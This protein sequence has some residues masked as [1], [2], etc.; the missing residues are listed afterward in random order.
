MRRLKWHHAGGLALRVAG[1]ALAGGGP[2][3]IATLVVT[4]V[5]NL[6]CAHCAVANTDGAMH[7]Y[8]ELVREMRLLHAGGIR[9]LFLM[10][11]ETALWRDG[12]RSIEDLIAAA[13]STGFYH[14][15]VVTNGTLTLTLPTASMVLLS[16]DGLRAH[17]D[18]IRGEGAF[19]AAMVSLDSA[20][21]TNISLYPAINRVN[22]DGIEGLCRLA[23]DHPKLAGISFNM[24]TP[25]PGTEQLSLSPEQKRE[26]VETILRLKREGLPVLNLDRALRT[27]LSGGWERPSRQCIISDGG[28]RWDCG[29]CRDVPGLC[30][31]C[32]YLFAIETGLL[33]RGDIAA[34][35]DA[36][37]TYARYVSDRPRR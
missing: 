18:R 30:E 17:N 31:E 6:S 1:E 36:I 8:D 2:P 37:R 5:C 34:S 11:G 33:F 24:H 28:T 12:D 16:L 21:D 35:L 14:V 26:A 22:V 3:L 23:A 4:D 15:N 19:D 20:Q 32:G 7:A 9:I 27:Y 10:G 13:W 25:Y 29:R